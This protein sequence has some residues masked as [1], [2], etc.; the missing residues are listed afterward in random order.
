MNIIKLILSL[1][2]A[3]HGMTDYI[4]SIETNNMTNLA[5]THSTGISSALIMPKKFLIPAL[6]TSTS[7][8]YR[9]DIP[10]K[11]PSNMLI[12]SLITVS[13]SKL[14]LNWMA[15]Y[16][17]LIHVPRHYREMSF[18]LEKKPRLTA[19][20]MTSSTFLMGCSALF[21]PNN[22]DIYD[23]GFLFRLLIGIVNSHILYEELIIRKNL[24]RFL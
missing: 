1:F 6:I 16:L 7:I 13:A 22:I 23:G 12:S 5:I 14:G 4:H 9:H 17:A 2:V 8:H 11:S 24:R 15:A 19:K 21:T 3:P 10:L 18:I 20:I